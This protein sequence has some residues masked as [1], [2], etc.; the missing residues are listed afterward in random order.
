MVLRFVLDRATGQK[1]LATISEVV[2]R[3]LPTILIGVV[4]GVM[5]GLTSVGSGSLMIVLMLFLYP[6]LGANQLV[7]TDL[8]QAVPLTLAAA[9]G[10]LIFGHVQIRDHGLAD[11]RQR[12]RR[13]RRLAAVLDRARP[14]RAAC[15]RVRDLRLRASSTSGMST[16]ALGWTLCATLLAI[17]VAW[18]AYARPWRRE[19]QSA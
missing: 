19:P 8:T 7:G 5:V 11:H 15:H 3:P 9:L 14:V 10:A 6:M 4:G 1:R 16:Q 2:P 18:L 17:S 12:P 13:A